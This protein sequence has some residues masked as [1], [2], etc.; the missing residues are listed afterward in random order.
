MLGAITGD[1]VGSRFESKNTFDYDFELFTRKSTFTDD[2]I[3][4]IAVADAV[5]RGR[6]YRDA[7]LE[8]CRKYPHRKGAYGASFSRWIASDNPKP[9]GS[10]GNGSAM[11]VSPVAYAFKKLEE[12]RRE[13][14]LTA[15]ISHNHPEGIKGAVSVAHAIFL[16]REGVSDE[17]LTAAMKEY[18]PFFLTKKFVRGR[19]DVTCQYTVP[20]CL[21]LFL[22]SRSFEDAIR[23]AISWGGDSD[24]I[25][26]IVGSMAEA[27]YSVPKAMAKKT[28]ALLPE[29]MRKVVDEFRGKFC[30]I[31]ND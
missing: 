25:G 14:E 24:T 5:L 12:V 22:A 17:E 3:C 19:F 10:F 13:A 9:Y 20:L 11:R 16:L 29:E 30:R 31:E 27:R 1:I 15:V 6:K 2:T 7:M 21:Q 23:K 28:L 4:T 8:W 26:A 18:Y